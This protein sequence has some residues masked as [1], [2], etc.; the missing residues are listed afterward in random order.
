MNINNQAS[1]IRGLIITCVTSALTWMCLYPPSCSKPNPSA[2]DQ[3]NAM[4][5][6][7]RQTMI[8]SAYQQK[9]Q[10]LNRQNDRLQAQLSVVKKKLVSQQRDILVQKKTVLSRL[11]PS[12]SPARN[13]Q[14]CDSLKIEVRGYIAQ[15]ET[16]D[17]LQQGIIDNLGQVIIVKDSILQNCE[18]D[19]ESMRNLADLSFAQQDKLEKDLGQARKQ[20][21]R[22]YL[23]NS[24]TAGTGI[25]LAGTCIALYLR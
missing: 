8:V 14:D 15:V 20:L 11:N 17:S 22:A 7:S 24:I 12:G 13:L 19:F 4:L 3:Q 9:N 1:L 2:A 18:Q 25:L 5:L 23:F 6:K 10:Q 16:Q 21:K